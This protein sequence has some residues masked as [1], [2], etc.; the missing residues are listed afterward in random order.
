M[1]DGQSVQSVHRGMRILELLAERGSMTASMIASELEIHQSSASRL[2]KSMM[3]YG[4]IYK[5]SF[6][7]FALDYG[8]VL[9]AGKALESFSLIQQ[10]PLISIDLYKRCGYSS[11][12]GVLFRQRL[13]YLDRCAK[14]KFV[15][16]DNSSFPLH[17]SS[18][19][20]LLAFRCGRPEALQIYNDSIRQSKSAER[21]E[22]IYD[23]IS[24][25]LSE[26]GFL[27]MREKYHNRFNA[28][29]DFVFQSRRV[30]LAIFSEEQL[31][32]AETIYP[33]IRDAVHSISGVDCAQAGGDLREVPGTFSKGIRTCR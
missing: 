14:G 30:A 8:V 22:D 21:A 11:A 24:A 6:H 20:R 16:V 18:I 9:F 5:P 3:D 26:Y 28:A 10:S 2:L 27:Y 1:T 15:L 33:V 19:G 17:M 31:V 29:W 25:S 23:E 7:S 32:S 4:F 13:V 12:L